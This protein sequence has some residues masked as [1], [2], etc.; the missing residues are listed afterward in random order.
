MFA[1]VFP[2][3]LLKKDRYI[4][5]HILWDFEPKQLMQPR[6]RVTEKGVEKVPYSAGY[7]L[8]IEAMDKTPGLFLMAQNLAGY[9]ETIAKIEGV[10][11][12]MIAEAIQENKSREYCRMYPVNNTLK[13]WLKKE[14]MV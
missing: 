11:E 2:L 6:C 9:A 5:E 4:V 14:F 3:H 8:Y 13:E 10:P 7:I 12:D 1:Q